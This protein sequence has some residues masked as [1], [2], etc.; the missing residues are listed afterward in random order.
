MTSL[1]DSTL[2]CSKKIQARKSS[3]FY[4]WILVHRKLSNCHID[5]SDFSSAA[6]PS[7]AMHKN[8]TVYHFP[9]A[10][11]KFLFYLS[12]LPISAF[13]AL[14]RSQIRFRTAV[15]LHRHGRLDAPYTIFS[16]YEKKLSATLISAIYP[17]VPVIKIVPSS[18]MSI[19][20]IPP[21]WF[22]LI[23]FSIRPFR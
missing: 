11:F 12:F 4:T 22:T 6:L 23:L 14:W 3:Y 20:I 16:F 21:G 18:L 7:T 10:A 1:T 17:T 2:I 19:W 8:Y 9:L 15:L 5:L 13:C